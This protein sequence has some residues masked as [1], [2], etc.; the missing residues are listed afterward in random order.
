MKDNAKVSI[1]KVKENIIKVSV[2]GKTIG[3]MRFVD[4]NWVAYEADSKRTLGFFEDK[5]MAIKAIVKTFVNKPI[6]NNLIY[7]SACIRPDLCLDGFCDQCEHGK[8]C[9]TSAKN[10]Y[11]RG[12]IYKRKNN[13][14][15]IAK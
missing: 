9:I 1:K 8:F 5:K 15:R 12:D 6:L 2:D 11:K 4:K 7:N 3:V 10:R 14:R 13:R